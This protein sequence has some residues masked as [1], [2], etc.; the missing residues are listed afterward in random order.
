M[1]KL[2]EAQLTSL[3]LNLSTNRYW[4]DEFNKQI[5]RWT[6]KRQS[7][8]DFYD[9]EIC[10]FHIMAL[11]AHID[12]IE[13]ELKMVKAFETSDCNLLSLHQH[14]EILIDNF[15]RHQQRIY[16]ARQID[17]LIGIRHPTI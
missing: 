1:S 17:L 9:Q 10:D 2:T 8:M 4:I 15:E 3:V 14:Y 16:E 7:L 6:S 11:R 13:C 5:D 12:V